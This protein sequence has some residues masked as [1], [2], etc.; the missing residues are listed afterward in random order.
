[1]ARPGVEDAGRGVAGLQPAL[2]DVSGR[3]P[4]SIDPVN[5]LG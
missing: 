3:K 2:V 4:R 5:P 1:M